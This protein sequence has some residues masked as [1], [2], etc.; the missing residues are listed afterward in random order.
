MQEESAISG[1]HAYSANLNKAFIQ[2]SD[3]A[4]NVYILLT[5]AKQSMG[6][7]TQSVRIPKASGIVVS[8]AT[9]RSLKRI[10]KAKLSKRFSTTCTHCE[11]INKRSFTYSWE[12]PQLTT[13]WQQVLRILAISDR[14]Q[15]R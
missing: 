2:V 14:V 9:K 13:S 6:S 4:L 15:Y 11:A 7:R 1:K 3:P 8:K 12:G 10:K 5:I